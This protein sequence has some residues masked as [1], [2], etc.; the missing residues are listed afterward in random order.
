MEKIQAQAGWGWG[1][2][3][4][5]ERERQ[6]QTE[7]AGEEESKTRFGGHLNPL[8]GGSPSRPPLANH[9]AL[10]GFD[11]LRALPSGWIL[12]QGSLGN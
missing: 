11:Q 9:L 7:R 3:V 1:R 10:S 12:A 5:R 4:E 2:C 8:Y 6:R